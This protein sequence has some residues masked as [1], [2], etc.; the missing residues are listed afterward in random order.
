MALTLNDV[1]NA[2]T[3]PNELDRHLIATGIV[4]PPAPPPASTPMA[5]PRTTIVPAT[6]EAK[7]ELGGMS[8]PNVP[9]GS[10]EL[11][12]APEMTAKVPEA[13]AMPSVKPMSPVN[14]TVGAL[15]GEAT[16]AGAMLMRKP[17]AGE[18]RQAYEDLRPKVTATPGTSEFYQQV[19]DR[20]EFD[21]QH[22]WGSDVSAH[23]GTLG[24]I[25]HVAGEIGNAIGNALVPGAMA[26]IP[27]TELYR[28]ITEGQTASAL[29][30]AKQRESQEATQ[31]LQ[32][33]NIESE[34][35]ERK[36]RLEQEL[37]KNNQSLVPDA[38]GNTVGWK[39]KDGTIHSV[40]DPDTPQAIKDIAA[41]EVNKVDAAKPTI[42]KLDNGDVVALTPG[43]D[44]QMKSQ[45]VYHGDPK[46][47]TDLTT[48]TVNGQEHHVLINR[49]NGQQIADL[50]AFKTEVS[51]AQELAHQKAD[52]EM[53]LGYDKDN[54]AHLMSRADAKEAGLQHISK[55]EAGAL[56]K[57]TTHTT[58]LNTL[59][60]Q[61]NNVAD[62]SDALDQ[63]IVQR[64]IIAKALSHPSNTTIDSLFRAGVMSG[65][66]E[67]TQKYVQAVIALR[68][69]G[70]ALPKE[71]TGGSRVSEVQASALW[72]GM[73]SASSL[74]QK[75]AIQQAKKFQSDIDRLRQ[76]APQ[77]RGIDLVDPSDSI[78]GATKGEK[79]SGGGNQSAA[80]TGG[81]TP[82]FSDFQ[83]KRQG[84]NP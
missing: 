44:G 28:Q 31:A 19:L 84:T 34:M 48:K 12:V 60:T 77:V 16:P 61:L 76:R 18:G 72:A 42:E 46:I 50:G 4:Q 14:T 56:D 35:G 7:L 55:A 71:I 20:E 21:K 22:P 82:S 36:Q 80:P 37:A 83:K 26:R 38:A 23:P 59:Q 15:P 29:A 1:L 49:K 3:D 24:K 68:E 45:V 6:R 10:S 39:D 53:V 65:A 62:S 43:A 47:E 33:Q 51:P 30:G 66:T 17:D 2:P 81:G 41:N 70:L 52:E 67:E 69:A 25:G 75:Y 11:P 64:T 5:Q 58:V 74:N 63:G 9:T 27:G 73:P 32:R 54:K 40:N 13:A 57:A 79:T 78:K 8:Q